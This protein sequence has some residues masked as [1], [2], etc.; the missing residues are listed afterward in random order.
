MEN[1]DFIEFLGWEGSYAKFKVKRGQLPN[2]RTIERIIVAHEGN[3]TTADG[4]W[5]YREYDSY[6]DVQKKLGSGLSFIA[7]EYSDVLKRS[8]I[9]YSFEYGSEVILAVPATGEEI[10]FEIYGSDRNHGLYLLVELEL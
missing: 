5:C 9:S 2:G 7:K 1:R 3:W 10:Y 8:L 6:E 4:M